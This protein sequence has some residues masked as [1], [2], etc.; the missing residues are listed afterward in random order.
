MNSK[1]ILARAKIGLRQPIPAF[2]QERQILRVGVEQNWGFRVLGVAPVP[3]VPI[4]HNQWWLVPIEQ[5]H[6]PIPERALE[7]VHA[8]YASGIR[9]RAFVIAHEVPLQLRPPANAPQ[10]S[11]LEFWA[12]RLTEHSVTVLKITGKVLTTVVLP[13][14]VTVLG[15]TLSAMVGLASVALADPCLIAVTE[16]N[17]WIQIDFW[18]TE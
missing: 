11:P 14:A 8:L 2:L 1:Q 18:M 17:V 10:I 9:P 4:F 12:G 3:P 13:L 5:D 15:V 6:S 16:D 7:R